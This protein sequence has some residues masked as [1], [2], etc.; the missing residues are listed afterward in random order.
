MSGTLHISVFFRS[1]LGHDNSKALSHNPSFSFS[2]PF[3]LIFNQLSERGV[4]Q[5][6]Q[7]ESSHTPFVDLAQPEANESRWFSSTVAFTTTSFAPIF[8]S[9]ELI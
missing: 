1:D 7:T 8:H 9:F 5:G 4:H 6:L 3:D 2:F